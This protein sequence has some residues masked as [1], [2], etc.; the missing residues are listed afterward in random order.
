V[1][2]LIDSQSLIWYVDQDHW[3][4]STAHSAIT[5]PFNDLLLSTAT[6]WEIAIKVGLKKLTLS[7]P[8][9][10]WM[11]RV[12]ADLGLVILPI[13]V[14]A[15]DTQVGLPWHH[16]DPFDRLIIAQALMENVPVVSVDEIF[17][18]YGIHR[19]WLPT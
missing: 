1:R 3:L 19:I 16:R 8:Y 7:L 18:Q 17:D 2:L 13:T 6:I 12:I 9:R 14:E 5:D 11:E 10:T 4:S 15:A